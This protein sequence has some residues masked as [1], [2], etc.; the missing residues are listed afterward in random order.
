LEARAAFWLRKPVIETRWFTISLM[1]AEVALSNKLD[2]AVE[3]LQ[4]N[5]QRWAALPVER[6]IEFVEVLV[7]DMLEESDDLVAKTMEAKGI[8]AGSSATGEE[9]ELGPVIIIRY[10]RLIRETLRQISQYGA[11]RIPPKKLRVR[12]SQV[13]VEVIPAS[14]F[15]RLLYLGA[16]GEVWMQPD[17]TRENLPQNVASFYRQRQPTGR[18]ALLLGAG[19]VAAIDFTDIVHE[20]FEE[21]EVCILKLN[22][23]NDYIGPCVEK[24]FASLIA[25]GFLRLTK[26]GAEVGAYLCNHPGIEKILITGNYRTYNNIVFGQGDEGEERRRLKKPKLL[27]PI[28]SEL[29]NVGPVIVVPGP[30]GQGDLRFQAENIATQ[31]ENNA[32]FN[33]NSARVLITHQGWSQRGAFVNSVR[34]VLRTSSPR[35]AYYPGAFERYRR[36]LE[37]H[38]EAEPLGSKGDGVIPWTLVA[39]LDP[40]V[41]ADVCFSEEPFCGVL[42]ETGLEARDATEFLKK[43]VAFSNET[44]FGNLSACII[45]HP[46]TA[47]ELGPLLEEAIAD[48]RYGTVG[49]NCWPA[50]GYGM[51]LPWGAFPGNI[52]DDI[53]SGTG[54]MVNFSMFDRP[55]KSVVYC[56]FRA[57]PKPAWF[58]TSK[59]VNAFPKLARFEA[60]PRWSALPSILLSALG[61]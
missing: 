50:L 57:R 13:I 61:A 29:G 5:K 46:K 11:P 33:C 35:R 45:V 49:I 6:K 20:L 18:V 32:A 27:K 25:E 12:N 55:Q 34:E 58:V 26:G 2:Q 30:W 37:T 14:P 10:L 47:S 22:P 54:F 7:R 43:A 15:D 31:V 48:L 42:A 16:R 51:G 28:T 44:L 8:A 36:I 52:A 60:N 59:A 1:A 40:S 9:W 21:G 19:N 39:G 38:P 24:V 3:L 56:P 41:S 4:T 23:V 17:V 53:Q